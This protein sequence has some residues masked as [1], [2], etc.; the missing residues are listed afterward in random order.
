[1]SQSEIIKT[2]GGRAVVINEQD[3]HFWANLY[4]GARQGL[5]HASITQT[6]WTGKTLKGAEKWAEKQLDKA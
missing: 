2:K 3:G 4:V 5:A 6:R 1:M